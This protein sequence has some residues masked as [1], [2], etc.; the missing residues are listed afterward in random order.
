MP[1]GGL[2]DMV[3][4]EQRCAAIRGAKGFPVRAAQWILW[5]GRHALHIHCAVMDRALRDAGPGADISTLFGRRRSDA[6][7]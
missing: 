3:M 7:S 6:T 1:G 4:G 2:H 5:L